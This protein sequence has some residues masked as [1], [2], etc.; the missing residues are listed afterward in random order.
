MDQV[1]TCASVSARSRIFENGASPAA[2]HRANHLLVGAKSGREA[3]RWHTTHQP[4][5]SRRR[6]THSVPLRATA[7]LPFLS[8]ALVNAVDRRWWW[9]TGGTDVDNAIRLRSLLIFC[10]ALFGVVLMV[11]CSELCW[12]GEECV[13]DTPPITALKCTMTV[14]SLVLAWY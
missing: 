5:E 14:S 8:I 10:N 3:G 11:T 2:L 4:A 12:N 1:L 6:A 13:A 9:L 7:I